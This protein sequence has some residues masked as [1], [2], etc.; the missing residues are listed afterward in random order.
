MLA[1]PAGPQEIRE[2]LGQRLRD[3]RLAQNLT[4]SALA[5]R[6]AVPV[7]TLKRFEHS[8][9]IALD[10]F[11][12]IVTALGLAHELEALFPAATPMTLDQLMAPTPK[13]LRGR[14]S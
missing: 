8:G 12:R 9:H 2:R 14:R 4:Q 3:L 7:S 1:T 5:A 13:R 10:A 11:V 6:A